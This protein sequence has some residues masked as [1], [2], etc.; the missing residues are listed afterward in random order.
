MSYSVLLVEAIC[1]VGFK[2]SF[3]QKIGIESAFDQRKLDTDVTDPNSQQLTS[4]FYLGRN[5]WVRSF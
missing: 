5:E 4:L 3:C 1:F 2:V